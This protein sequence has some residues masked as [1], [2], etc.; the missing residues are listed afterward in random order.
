[1]Y[2][3]QQPQ[4][5]YSPPDPGYEQMIARLNKPSKMPWFLLFLVLGGGGY[6]AYKLWES[7]SQALTK[8]AAGEEAEKAKKALEERLKTV[9]DEKA[10]VE[11]ARAALQKSVD[12]KSSELAE[13]KG[14]YDKLNEKM[15]DEI[16]HGDIL[17]TQ[18]GGRLRVDLVD[19]IL[20]ESGDARISKRGESVLSRVGSV[21]ADIEDKQIQVSGH[22]DNEPISD[23]LKAQYPTNWELSVARATNVVRFLQEQAK[24][25]PDRLVASGYG[26]HHPVA[27]NKNPR[28]RARNRRI[29]LLLTRPFAPKLISKAKLKEQTEPKAKTADAAP[30][31]APKK[32]TGRP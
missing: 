29:E 26:E 16:A 32:K 21:L 25:P 22:T 31:A 19:K 27:S 20:F 10:G 4:G 8:A 24:V 12:E 11:A 9:E 13:L 17:L 18:S 3:P 30:A 2:P 28:G 5:G 23:K 6:G 7:R 14:T 1:M 15:K